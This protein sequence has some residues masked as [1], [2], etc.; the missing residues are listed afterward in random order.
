MDTKQSPWPGNE[1]RPGEIAGCEEKDSPTQKVISTARDLYCTNLHTCKADQKSAEKAYDRSVRLYR[2]KKMLFEW[3]ENNYRLYRNFDI[4]LDNQLTTGNA[5]LT[6]NVKTY[7]TLSTSLYTTLKQVV[8]GITDLKS[9]VSALRD[10]ASSLDNYKN[11]QANATQ[12]ALL[13]GKS[14][15]NCKPEEG[16]HPRPEPCKDADLLYNDLIHVPKKVLVFDV[17]SLLQSAQDTVGI[18]TFTNIDI[19]TTQQ[20]ALTT[21]SAALVTQVTTSL[22]ARTTDLATTQADLVAAVQECTTAGVNKYNVISICD[23]AHH[24]VQFLCCPDCKCVRPWE[25]DPHRPVLEDCECR[26]CHICEC[27]KNVYPHGQEP[28]ED[29]GCRE[30][31]HGPREG[32]N[33]PRNGGSNIQ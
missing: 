15:D 22:K 17:D 28:E 31:G 24:T 32:G 29:C 4:C 20:T 18:Q 33:G 6:A 9:K 10:Q 11:D 1:K 16:H 2:K 13:T 3:T 14:M 8:A 25:T 5:S 30:G 21:A 12:W 27:V 26:I 19:L 23:G 7:S